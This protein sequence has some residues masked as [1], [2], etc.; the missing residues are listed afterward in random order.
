LLA[1][2]TVGLFYELWR[3]PIT[4]ARNAP[5][6]Q[7]HGFVSD[8]TTV[9]RSPW[10]RIVILMA[11]VWRHTRPSPEAMQTIAILAGCAIVAVLLGQLNENLAL[12]FVVAVAAASYAWPRLQRQH[13]T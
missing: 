1:V 4:H 2:A 5:V 8:Y 12:F 7:G 11:W 3:N 10:A 6:Q 9:L 13:A